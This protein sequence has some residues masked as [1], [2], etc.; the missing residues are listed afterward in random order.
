MTGNWLFGGLSGD[1]IGC[2]G[3]EERGGRSRSIAWIRLLWRTDV[4][5]K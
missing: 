1:E 5:D 3:S 2:P 4:I